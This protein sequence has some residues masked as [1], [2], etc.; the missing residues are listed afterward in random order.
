MP[1]AAK[2]GFGAKLK[3]GDGGGTEVFT[4]VG[5]ILSLDVMSLKRDT[6]DVSNMDSS[7]YKEFI[8]G[9]LIDPGEVG[10]E[11]NFVPANA[12][13]I[14]LRTDM[15]NRTLR[16]FK[17]TLPAA[18]TVTASFAGYVTEWSTSAGMDEAMKLK[19]SIKISGPIVWS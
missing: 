14:G 18:T 16:N 4:D 19:A 13:Q 8:A 7:G 10:V 9:A 5:E 12:Q 17:I 2:I 1:T 3:R 11:C 15:E 6:L